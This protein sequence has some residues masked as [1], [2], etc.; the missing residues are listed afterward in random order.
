MYSGTVSPLK[1]SLYSRIFPKEGM[2]LSA[3]LDTGP[4]PVTGQIAATPSALFIPDFLNCRV[5][6]G[7]S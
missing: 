4:V 5:T 6:K 2:T 7:Y 1:Y 3:L